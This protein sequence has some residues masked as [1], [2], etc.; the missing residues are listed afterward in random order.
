MKV[1]YEEDY[2]DDYEYSY[3]E[4]YHEDIFVYSFEN[5]TVRTG[6]CGKGNNKIAWRIAQDSVYDP[7]LGPRSGYKFLG[8]LIITGNGMMADYDRKIE[9]TDDIS[10]S[11]WKEFDDYINYVDIQSGITSIGKYAFAGLKMKEVEF[12]DTLKYIGECAFQDTLIYD[13]DLPEGL[14]V[15]GEGAFRGAKI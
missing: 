4:Y 10:E 6:V 13:P 5:R 1:Y 14:T 11:P 9:G 8:Y 2:G 15:I 7:E 12:P 3:E